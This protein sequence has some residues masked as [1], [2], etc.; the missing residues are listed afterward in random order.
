MI[1]NMNAALI[2]LIL[3]APIGLVLAQCTPSST[4]EINPDPTW[5]DRVPETVVFER[6][7]KPIL[8]IQCVQCHNS[9]D[10]K[11]NAN[12]NLE[13]RKLALSTGRRPPVI[14]PGD[15]ENSLFVQVLEL[16]ATH[17]TNMPPSPDKLWGVRMQ[18]IKK[19]I[20]QGAVWPEDVR[21]VRP[22]DWAE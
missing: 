9:V 19:W 14:R 21:M 5:P 11:D 18:I 2:R 10:A 15:P 4:T 3:L 7:L 17:P 12:L 20:A 16:E 22:Q 1:R 8:E 13:T 6:D